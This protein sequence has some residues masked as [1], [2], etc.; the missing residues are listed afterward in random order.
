[1][2]FFTFYGLENNHL[3]QLPSEFKLLILRKKVILSIAILSLSHPVRQLSA[4]KDMGMEVKDDLSAFP[5]AINNEPETLLSDAFNPGHL[6]R[7]RKQG[8][9]KIRLARL[10]I[11]QR[12]HML[13]RNHNDVYGCSRVNVIK[14]QDSVRFIDLAAW[15]LSLDD[16]AEY[17]FFH[18]SPPL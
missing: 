5:V 2:M 1:M 13:F 11:K 8:L 18:I 10:K 15:N 7:R 16:L 9:R 6:I 3:L 14:G 12:G 4:P 17:A